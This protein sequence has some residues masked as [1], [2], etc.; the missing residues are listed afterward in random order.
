MRNAGPNHSDVIVIGAGGCGLTAGLVAARNGA[1]VL[2]LEKTDKPGGGTAFSTKGIR[3]AG[4]RF[5][6]V[7]GID[8]SPEQYA[9]DIL[10]RNGYESDVDLTRRLTETCGPVANLLADIAGVEF[11]VGDF[12]FGHSARRSHSWKADKKITDFLFEAVQREPGIEVR[13]STPVRSIIQSETGAVSGVVTDD[14][15]FLVSKII[16]ASGGFGASPDLLSEYIPAA[17]GI[18]FPGHAGSTGDGIRIGMLLGAAVEHMGAFQPYPAYVGPEKQSVSPE[19]AISGGIMVDVHGKRFVDETKYPGGLSAGMLALP[20]KR[21]F[22]IFDERVYQ[23]HSDLLASF[24]ADGLL[25]QAQD[26]G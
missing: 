5:Q 20:D 4:T 26:S 10:R 6:Q 23:S 7:L 3:A 12:A 22:E 1:R 8:D 19:V 16:I 24:R 17:V 25:R 21:A 11:T 9:Q 18:P 15:S 14:E 13:F 2:L